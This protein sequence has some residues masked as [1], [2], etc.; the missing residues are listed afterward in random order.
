MNKGFS[1]GT[2]YF[3]SPKV[4]NNINSNQHNF[5]YNHW[6]FVIL[7]IQKSSYTIDEVWYSHLSMFHDTFI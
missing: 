3:A 1:F 5:T 4:I 7:V 6:K 2:R